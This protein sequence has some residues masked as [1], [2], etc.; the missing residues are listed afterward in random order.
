[1]PVYR[2]KLSVDGRDHLFHDVSGLETSYE[3]IEHRDGSGTTHLMPGQRRTATVSL[4]RGSADGY[5][6]L[7]D[8]I[9]TIGLN[10]VDRKDVTVSLLNG[11]RTPAVSWTVTAAFPSTLTSLVHGDG[12][13]RPVIGELVLRSPLVVPRFGA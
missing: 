4:R 12:A 3:V 10:T 9:D 5:Q 6:A 11:P 1:M 2:Y 13:D 7:C 8:W